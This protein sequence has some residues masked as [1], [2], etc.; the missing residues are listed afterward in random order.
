MDAAKRV[1]FVQAAG[2]PYGLIATAAS[3][4]DLKT[5]GDVVAW[6]QKAA[7][8]P[9]VFLC[10]SSGCPT[11]QLYEERLNE[12]FSTSGARLYLLASNYNDDPTP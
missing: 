8:A 9:I 10:W 7:T 11:C 4:K 1:A 2:H 5:L 6:V 12:I 3:T